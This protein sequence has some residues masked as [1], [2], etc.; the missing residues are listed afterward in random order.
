[1]GT[2]KNF[3]RNLL[4]AGPA[5]SLLRSCGWSQ[6][7]LSVE[8]TVRSVS[9]PPENLREPEEVGEESLAS[10]ARQSGARR[11]SSLLSFL[12]GQLRSRG[13]ICTS[14]ILGAGRGG[15]GAGH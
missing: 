10:L 13:C 9:E 12:A 7:P 3:D 1:M 4:R 2:L 5:A 8:V 14:T 15:A 6:S 11:P